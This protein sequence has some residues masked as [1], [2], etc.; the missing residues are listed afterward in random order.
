MEQPNEIEIVWHSGQL[1][2]N[3]VQSQ[4]KSAIR[5]GYENAAAA[6]DDY[7]RLSANG[8]N[9]LKPVSQPRGSPQLPFL[10]IVNV[11]EDFLFG[12]VTLHQLYGER[13]SS[14]RLCKSLRMEFC[15]GFLIMGTSSRRPAVTSMENKHVDVFSQSLEQWDAA[16]LHNEC[17]DEAWGA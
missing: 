16:L 14:R 7:N 17:S 12:F 11:Q 10:C 8:H 2:T 4:K 9:P 6:L 5:H 3:C 1:A 15:A 13:T